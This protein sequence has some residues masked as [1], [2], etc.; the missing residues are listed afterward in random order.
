MSKPFMDAMHFRFACREFD[1]GRRVEKADLDL[2]LEAGRLSPSS[3]GLEHWRFVVAESAAARRALQDACEGQPQVG[4]SAAV[5]VILALTADL[6][7]DGEYVKRMLRREAPDEAGYRDF[8]AFYRRFAGGVDLRGWSITQCHIAAANMMTAAASLGID[9]CPVGA[10]DEAAVL[11]A[12]GVDPGRFA[13]A[14]VLP[15]G[16]RRGPQP[17]RQRL[18]PGELALK[19]I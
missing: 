18:S 13:V 1:R 17:P 10:F 7:P 15:L 9:S 8:L 4:A 3:M 19:R 16:Y 2:I 11:K 6:A 14:L 5:I 12:T